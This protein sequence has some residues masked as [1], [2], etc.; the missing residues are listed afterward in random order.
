MKKISFFK[1]TAVA[2][3]II[4]ALCLPLTAYA[5]EKKGSVSVLFHHETYP[6]ADSQF[7][8]YRIADEINGK[9]FLRGDFTKYPVSLETLTSDTL[10]G[11]ANALSAYAARDSVK[12]YA[13]GKTN[14]RG[15][16]VFS[17]LEKGLYLI[18]GSAV[19]EKNKIYTPQ[20]F[21]VSVP[22]TD[23]NGNKLYNISAE[24]KYDVHDKNTNGN[25]VDRSVRKLW[26]NDTA[27]KRPESITVQLLRNGEIY[28]EI[29]LNVSNN[30]SHTWKDLEASY[31]WQITEKTVSANY[32]VSFE[33]Q[34]TTFILTNTY[35]DS[36]NPSAPDDNTKPDNPSNPDNTTDP[37]GSDST[38]T[39][40]NPNEPGNSTNPNEPNN[41]DKTTR[42][43]KPDNPFNP[44]EP[45]T[46]PSPFLPQTG[47]LWWPVPLC[48]GIGLIL[49]GIGAAL[50]KRNEEK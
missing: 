1:L 16:V 47:Q 27:N 34:N 17:D 43:N 21:I 45:T 30:W 48:I 28:D 42:P 20:P 12:P 10:G 15:R 23:E 5:A 11:I 24:P 19:T 31:T 3:C 40:D 50:K 39:P 32:T 46:K 33:R 44:D 4:T 13:E 37:N 25:T 35:G 7:K 22:F 9:Y 2:L 38:T 41:P 29:I 36:E 26:R 6:V 18:V 8:V 14:T 49:F